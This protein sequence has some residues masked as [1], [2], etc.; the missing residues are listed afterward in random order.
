M[1]SGV[2]WQLKG[3]R[4]EVVDSAREAARRSGLSVEEW[5]DTVISES[6]R[7]AG[8]DPA[9]DRFVT[10][11]DAPSL[12]EVNARLDLLSRQL[13]ELQAAGARQGTH[14]NAGAGDSSRLIADV[15][16][17]LDRKIDRMVEDWRTASS[18]IER[19]VSALDRAMPRLHPHAAGANGASL[20]SPASAADPTPAES[21]ARQRPVN[22][23]AT[24]A[25]IDFPR[26][27]T[28]RL[29]DL[30]QQLR[31]INARFDA[32]PS[33]RVDGAVDGLRGDL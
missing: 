31:Q 3:V 14:R 23:S 8:I 10:F 26:A 9:T 7:T 12:M 27:P 4:R 13:D 20:T 19:R 17:R 5:L 25:P 21:E 28:Q 24:A 22:G 11:D 1:T 29:P 33:C 30:E 2:P 18:E 6:A 32:M 16:A 15:V